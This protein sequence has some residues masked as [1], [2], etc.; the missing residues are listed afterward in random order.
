MPH[1]KCLN[2]PPG[3]RESCKTLFFSEKLQ[4]FTTD[5]EYGLMQRSK[6]LD[7]DHPEH[8]YAPKL[9][10][11]DP[12]GYYESTSARPLP[13]AERNITMFLSRNQP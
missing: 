4:T 2:I 6:S 1:T 12:L 9:H 13:F 3:Y 10:G 7:D 8:D 11:D 5:K